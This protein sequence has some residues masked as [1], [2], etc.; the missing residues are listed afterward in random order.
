[1]EEYFEFIGGKWEEATGKGRGI[2]L[3]F[4]WPQ[5]VASLAMDVVLSV[6]ERLAKIDPSFCGLFSTPSADNRWN[7][8]GK[9]A[10][11]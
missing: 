1:M 2:K 4:T 9:F 10:F 3:L 8:C 7:T 6:Q 5:P 11:G